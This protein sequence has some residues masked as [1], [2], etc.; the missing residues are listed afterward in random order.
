MGLYIRDDVQFHLQNYLCATTND[1]ECLW[2]KINRK[3]R[4]IICAVIY[5]HPIGNLDNFADY[6]MITSQLTYTVEVN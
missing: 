6:L 2:I 4:N 1:Y 3:T 5:R